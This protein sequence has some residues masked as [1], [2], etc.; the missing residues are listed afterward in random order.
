MYI[1]YNHSN[2]YYVHYIYY[3]YHT[4]YTVVHVEVLLYIH[5][6]LYYTCYTRHF[7]ISRVKIWLLWLYWLHKK[8]SFFTVNCV[9]LKVKYSS[10]IQVLRKYVRY[11]ISDRNRHSVC[12]THLS[13][14]HTHILKVRVD[15]SC[16]VNVLITSF[17]RF[18]SL[19]VRW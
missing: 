1:N 14:Y 11:C 2:I 8:F 13:W 5:N 9:C 6:V 19:Y 18:V 3:I 15:W 7:E 4:M 16:V 12:I 17:N 10:I